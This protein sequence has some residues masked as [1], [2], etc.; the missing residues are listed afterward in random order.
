MYKFPSVLI[1]IVVFSP[2]IA[3]DIP[4][5]GSFLIDFVKFCFRTLGIVGLGF[6]ICKVEKEISNMLLFQECEQIKFRTEK[7]Y[8]WR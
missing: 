1:G 8:V 3:F 5:L 7:D 2:N 6:F 4:T